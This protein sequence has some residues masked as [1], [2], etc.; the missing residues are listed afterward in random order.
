M[1]LKWKASCCFLLF[2]GNKT[3]YIYWYNLLN[4]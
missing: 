3:G 4:N 2:E 1:F